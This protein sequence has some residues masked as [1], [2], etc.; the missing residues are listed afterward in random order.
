MTRLNGGNPAKRNAA[1][2]E[3]SRGGIGVSMIT[4]LYTD[5]LVLSTGGVGAVSL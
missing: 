3:D 2:A 1:R 5:K 4:P